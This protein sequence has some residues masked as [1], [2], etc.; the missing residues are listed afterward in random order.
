MENHKRS[1]VTCDVEDRISNLSEDLINSIL[2]YLPVQDAV[3]TSILSKK[4]R[5]T[6]TKMR[7]LV[8]NEQF[9]KRFGKNGA[10]G[11]NGFVRIIN[12]VI[13]FHNGPVSKF[14]LYIPNVI[15]DSFQEIDQWLL[16]LSR[17]SVQELNLINSNR[18]YKLPSY[19]S[20]C[21][22]LRIFR[23]ENCIFKPPHDL[24]EFLHLK[25]LY[26]SKIDFGANSYGT[27]FN[28]PELEELMLVTC[29]NVCNFNIKAKRLQRLVV[30]T[31]P[32]DAILLPSFQITCLITLCLV[33][34][35]REGFQQVDRTNLT[36]MLS[37]LRNIIDLSVDGFYVKFFIADKTPKQLPHSLKRLELININFCD[38]DQLHGAIFLL[39]N[40]P[41][42]NLLRVFQLPSLGRYVMQ[43]DVESTSNYLCTLDSLNQT[44]KQLRTIEILDVEG[45]R[46]EMLF[47]KL[48]LTHSSSLEKM[49]IRPSADA[50]THKRLN[51]AMD[52]MRFPRASPKAEMLYLDPMPLSSKRAFQL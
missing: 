39:Q 18:Y 30:I 47:I 26:L 4:W 3:R 38:L 45:L 20:S 22:E 23:L 43:F 46:P 50:D 34:Y 6:W 28:L 52:V 2:E 37:C 11:H 12:H 7:A 1:F 27:L 32:P 36:R 9:F 42:L 49:T 25:N 21:K 41:N 40:S 10:F 14:G 19:V 15:L 17:N 8:F 29:T 31:Y 48:L 33:S 35:I 13:F 44:L 24:Q 16:F 5:Y 51:I